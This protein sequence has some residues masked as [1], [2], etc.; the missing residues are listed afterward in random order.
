LYVLIYG[1]IFLYMVECFEYLVY[2]FICTVVWFVYM[3]V[4]VC[5]VV[6]FLR[7]VVFC[8]LLFNFVNYVFLLSCM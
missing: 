2:V 8:M 4:F 7:L 6:C 5:M 1:C 3:D